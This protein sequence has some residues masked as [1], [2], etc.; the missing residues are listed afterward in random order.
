[1]LGQL[2]ST[3]SAKIP[4][5][6]GRV[7]KA[8]RLALQGDVELTSSTT[9]TVH[10]LSDP[11]TS[12][13]ITPGLCTC[14][15]YSHAPE[16]LCCH[17]LAAGFVRKIAEILAAEAPPAPKL[18]QLDNLPEAPASATAKVM[19]GAYEVLLTVRDSDESRLLARLQGLLKDPRIQP[20]PKPAPRPQG[21][22]KQRY[23]G[24]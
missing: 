6:N 18:S 12:Y 17:R 15:D 20:P 19:L 1:V 16:H 2:A 23:K 5:L 14:K 11:T 4:T 3:T 21:Q 13:A 9:A 24:A 22:W 10:S 8:C 7:E